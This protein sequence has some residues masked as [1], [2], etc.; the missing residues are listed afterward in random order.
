MFHTRDLSLDHVQP[1]CR[2]GQLVWNNAVTCCK[3][4]NGRKGSK[5]VSELKHIGMELKREPR[6]PT[7]TELAKIA[8]RLTPRA[9]H[10]SWLPY[11]PYVAATTTT[12]EVETAVTTTTATT[13]ASTATILD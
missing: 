8:G 2:G 12:F 3:L 7:Q 13:A 6:T 9:L 4:C 11:L 1:R 10:P 5:T